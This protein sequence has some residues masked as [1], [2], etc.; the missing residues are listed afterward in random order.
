MG[1]VH[2]GF[3][4][5][6][7]KGGG[8]SLL[9]FAKAF[10]LVIANS[11][12]PTREEHLVTFQS[13]VAKTQIDYFFLGRCDRGLCEDY[14]V[15]PGETLATQYRL[16]VM[17]VGIIIRRKKRSSRG[18]TRIRWGTLTKDKSREMDGRLSSMGA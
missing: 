15:I 2:G 6:V 11:N 4:F 12:F 5:G 9:E 14:K 13:M 16:L 17:D 10:E 1:E 3:G 8:T 7:T 18:R